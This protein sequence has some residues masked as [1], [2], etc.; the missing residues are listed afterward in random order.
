MRRKDRNSFSLVRHLSFVLRMGTSSQMEVLKTSLLGRIKRLRPVLL[1]SSR[2][3]L[4][5]YH[6]DRQWEL[7]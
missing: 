3:I 5:R 1:A 2:V 4:R 6:R 7:G